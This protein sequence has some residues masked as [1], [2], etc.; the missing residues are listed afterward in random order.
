MNLLDLIVVVILILGAYRGW[1]YGGFSAAISLF[2]SLLVFVLAYYLKDPIAE[3]MYIN[4]PFRAFGGIFA[5]ITSFNIL[6]YLNV[7][8]YMF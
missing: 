1:K 2:G 8:Q 6:V 7:A 3:L 4:L 5:G